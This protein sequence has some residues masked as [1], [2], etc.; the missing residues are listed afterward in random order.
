MKYTKYPE[1]KI[2]LKQLAKEIREWKAN[3]KQDKRT[4]LK[5]RQWEIQSQVDWRSCEFRHKLC[6]GA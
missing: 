6:V 1:L 3:R 2:R 4:K 5:M